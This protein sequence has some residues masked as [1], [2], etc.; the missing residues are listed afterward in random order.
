[1]AGRRRA[2]RCGDGRVSPLGTLV[3]TVRSAVRNW[4]QQLRAVRVTPVVGAVAFVLM[5]VSWVA[6]VA[7]LAIAFLALN[8]APPWTGLLLASCSGQIAA[9]MTETPGWIRV[10][11]CSITRT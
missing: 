3:L 2:A 11:E 5:M 1:M 8:S 10:V 9:S 4:A 7:V 6:D